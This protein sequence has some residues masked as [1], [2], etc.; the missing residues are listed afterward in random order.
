MRPTE[1][2]LICILHSG[3]YERVRFTLAAAAAAAAADRDVTLFFTM[4]ASVALRRDSGWRGLQSAG[5]GALEADTALR[6]KGVAGFEELLGA[7][8]DLGVRLVVCEMG[9]RARELTKAELDPNLDLEIGGL[10]SL[11][12]GDGADAQLLFV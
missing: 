7:C 9:L 3:D 1:R 5:G 11:L 8:R 2:S 6:D 12:A 10:F 4:D